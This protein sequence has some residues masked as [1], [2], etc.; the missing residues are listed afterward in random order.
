MANVSPIAD[1]SYR[2]YDG[3]LESPNHRWWVI[4][5]M[6]LRLA[7]KKWG[8][9]VL[10]IMSGWYYIVM[11]IVMFV[12]EQIVT[13]SLGRDM[14]AVKRLA[15]MDWTEQFLHGFSY[16]QIWYFLIALMIGAGSIA[17]D[18]KANA[19]LSYLSKP[20][21]KTDYVVGK[22][23][24]IFII[25]CAAA[26]IPGLFFFGYGAMN[27]REYG[28]VSQDHWLLPKFLL[29]VPVAAAFQASLILGVSSMFRQ[30]MHAGLSYA[31]LYLVTNFF[32]VMM[33]LAYNLS[34][35]MGQGRKHVDMGSFSPAP[36]TFFS[37]D[38]VQIGLAKIILNT[39]GGQAFMPRG[40]GR[41]GPQ[42]VPIPSLLL[43]P[44]AVAV[45]GAFIW[46]AWTKIRAVEVVR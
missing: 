8:L 18:N 17:N 39:A 36:F 13:N 6:M 42:P 5:K 35:G 26:I 14:G 3:M 20:C 9:Y 25:L 4:T 33:T 28:F 40:M 22:W 24:G 2:S 19:L 38:G 44:I 31:G 37:I 43:I 45:A 30:G 27:W 32:T 11:M 46:F 1:L 12:Q 15:N 23:M 29:L 10:T 34:H 41:M 7:V 21:T 16:G